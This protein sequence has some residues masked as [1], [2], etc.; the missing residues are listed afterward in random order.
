MV[1]HVIKGQTITFRGVK[2][3]GAAGVQISIKG[4]SKSF[5]NEERLVFEEE[6]E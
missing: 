6:R 4:L 3:G 1:F 5:Q 2:G